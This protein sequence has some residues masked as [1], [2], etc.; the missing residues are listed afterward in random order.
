MAI[1][2]NRIKNRNNLFELSKFI[3]YSIGRFSTIILLSSSCYLLYF[4]IPKPISN[5]VIETAGK[6]LSAGSLIYNKTVNS[7][8]WVNSRLSYFKDLE[9]TNLKLKLQVVHLQKTI[10]ITSDLQAENRTLKQML[11][12][13]KDVAKNFVTAKVIGISS[14]PFASSVTLQSG[15]RNN[16]KINDIVRGS[17]GLIGRIS[18]VSENYSTAV[19]IND[20][21]SR[22]P[23]V[24]STSKAKGVIA[25]QDDNLK[26]IY[27]EEDHNIS[28]GETLYTSGD[29]R[30]FPKGITVATIVNITGNTASVKEVEQFNKIEYV[31]IES[32]S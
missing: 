20:H 26:I 27:L 25:R 1:L 15:S 21:N 24:T 29:G 10:Q 28:V 5:I 22:I 4:S 17:S 3:I 16:I 31:V 19:L 13:T 23:V 11:N 9:V 14:T 8:R 12:V 2:A 18:E 7:F 30:I 32:N 6:T